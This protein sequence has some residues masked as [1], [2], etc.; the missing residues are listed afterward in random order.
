[1]LPLYWLSYIIPKDRNLWVFGAWS[2][3]RYADN[4]KYLFEYINKNYSEIRAIWFT[5]N[6]DV[7]KLVKSKG[8]EVYYGYSLQSVLL[9]LRASCSIFVQSNLSDCMPFLNNKKTKLVQLWHGIPLKKI[10]YDDNLSTHRERRFLL[11]NIVFPFLKENYSFIIANSNEDEGNFITAFRNKSVKITGY[12]RNDLLFQ[13]VKRGK[14]CNIIYLP[15]LRGNTG[16]EIDLFSNFGFDVSKIDDF[17]LK[18]HCILNIKMHP[19]NQ[20]NKEM[21]EQ[22]K[23]M[24]NINFI[25]EKDATEMLMFADIL[26][27]DYS[28]V[29]F[30]YLLT[31]KPIIF[32]PFDYDDYI[33]KGREF[34]Y[35][36]D[37]VTPGPKCKDWNEIL[38]WI[39]KFKND[40]TLFSKERKI[41]KNRFHKYQDGRSCERVY[42]EIINVLN[43]R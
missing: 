6:K 22:I 20:P 41:M 10:G 26:I 37:E 25:I 27:T 4:S 36:Y 12:P 2:G 39:E 28:S 31:D 3:E 1:M 7:Y 21:L 40:P 43:N 9:G 17:L 19:V 24:N 11:R 14:F 35:N 16:D 15:T 33:R 32:A 30:D 18:N 29:Y 38:T 5:R 8:Y 13:K 34:Y 23:I 42:N